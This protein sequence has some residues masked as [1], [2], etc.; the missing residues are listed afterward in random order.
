L[1]LVTNSCGAAET[2]TVTD[3]K[4][5]RVSVD[6]WKILTQLG[7]FGES[8]GDIVERVTRHYMTCP[9]VKRQK[10]QKD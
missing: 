8:Y 7:E 2:V 10:K 1:S 6:T 5:L 3:I 4:Q 9:E